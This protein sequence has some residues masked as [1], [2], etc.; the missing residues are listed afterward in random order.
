MAII[1]GVDCSTPITASVARSLNELGYHFVCRY[2]VPDKYPKHLSADEAHH[3]TDAGLSIVSVFETSAGRARGGASYGTSDG[4]DALQAA[5]S[6]KMPVSG[7]IYFAV[8]FNAADGDM[9]AIESYL[10][11]AKTSMGPYKIGVYGSFSVVE[12]MAK[13]RACDSFWQTY[14]WSGGKK[15]QNAAI[16]QYLN[17]QSAAGITVDYDE[18]YD[19]TGMWNLNSGT[20]SELTMT[21]E[22]ARKELTDVSGKG[23]AHSPWADAAV[24]KLTKAG[25][26]SGDGNGN[27]GWEQCMT[28]EAVATALYKTLEKLGLLDK[29]S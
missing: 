11:A 10:K 12:E 26:I 20:G 15:S 19:D 8:D 2:L 4:M 3:L 22:E 18:A 29:L 14:S 6:V 13:R 16:Y 21:I 1:K 25:I 17:G 28:R 7:T 27:F 23:A 5:L 9:D 24:E